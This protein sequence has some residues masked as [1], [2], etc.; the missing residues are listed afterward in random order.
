MRIGFSFSKFFAS[1][2]NRRTFFMMSSCL[3]A[4]ELVTSELSFLITIFDLFCVMTIW[5]Q[6]S[7]MVDGSSSMKRRVPFF[8]IPGFYAGTMHSL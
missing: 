5:L 6:F 3:F 8:F 1:L 7:G 4:T 2:K